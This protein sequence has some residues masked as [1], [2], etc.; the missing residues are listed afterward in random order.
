VSL[1]AAVAMLPANRVGFSASDAIAICLS[2]GQQHQSGQ[3]ALRVCFG[4]G[5]CR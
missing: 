3:R 4:S 1:H 5:S 2:W